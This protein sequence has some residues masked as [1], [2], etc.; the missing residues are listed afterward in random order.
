MTKALEAA[1]H[2]DQ[3]LTRFDGASIG[4]LSDLGQH[5]DLVAVWRADHTDKAA[6]LHDAAPA[7]L[8]QTQPRRFALL[9]GPKALALKPSVDLGRNCMQTFVACKAR[10]G[11]DQRIVFMDRDT[12][13][14]R[15]GIQID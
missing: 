2:L 8:G 3:K 15:H 9:S 13:H 5:L 11:F 12:A 6:D 1:K 10:L 14:P 4:Y 7:A